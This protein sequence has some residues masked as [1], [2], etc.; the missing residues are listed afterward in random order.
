M[1][2]VKLMIINTITQSTPTHLLLISYSSPTHPLPNN[3]KSRRKLVE[4]KMI[5]CL[6]HD[7]N[8][9]DKIRKDIQNQVI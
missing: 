3:Y 8:V 4:E 9:M 5:V 6:E 7:F 1:L 2:T